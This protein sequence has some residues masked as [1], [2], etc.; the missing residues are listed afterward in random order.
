MSWRT[1]AQ[2]RLGAIYLEVRE[3]LAQ[4]Q[5]KE[6]RTKVK[7]AYAWGERKYTPYKIWCEEVHKAF[8]T[9]YPRRAVPMAT[10]ETPLGLEET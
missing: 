8:P 9:L 4:G 6:A 7:E 5:L 1:S 3:L 2:L 10:L